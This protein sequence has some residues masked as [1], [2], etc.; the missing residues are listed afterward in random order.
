MSLQRHQ[1]GPPR[2][3]LH[4][5]VSLAG[6]GCAYTGANVSAILRKPSIAVATWSVLVLGLFAWRGDLSLGTPEQREQRAVALK[7]P[8][9]VV[10][11]RPVT[12]ELPRTQR[13]GRVFDSMG[14]L[15][16]GAEV[17]PTE[18]TSLKTDADGM[19]SV[20][21]L[22]YQTSDLLV[23]APGRRHEWLRTSALSPDP[24]TICMEPS[25]PWDTLPEPLEPVAKLRGE[26]AV[27]GVDRRPLANAFV[28][29]LG[30]D[31][32]GVTDETGRFELPLPSLTGRFVV[33]QLGGEGGLGGLASLSAPF[34]SPR[35]S[36]IVPLPTLVGQPAGSIRGTVRTV[37]GAAIA[38]LPIEVRGPGGRR[39]VTTGAGGVFVLSGLVPADYTVE[40]FAYRGAVGEAVAVKVDRAMVECDLHLTKIEAANVRVVDENGAIAVGVWVSSSL[41]GLRRGIDQAGSDG[42]VN[43]PV[44]ASSKFEVRMA[45]SFASCLVRQYNADAEPATLVIA[46]P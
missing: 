46:Q 44:G 9:P 14:F 27:Q 24:L 19:F 20:D 6:S 17:V 16:V 5:R 42:F 30:T 28:N 12:P 26:G 18:G 29:V 37:G 39:R 41:H 31:C 22:R 15:L 11:R 3:K 36:G 43:L 33:H 10:V 40:P 21:L 1:D 35:A 45:D 8:E 4:R 25:A 38:G 34:V 23:R 13:S 7:Q 32:W 2:V